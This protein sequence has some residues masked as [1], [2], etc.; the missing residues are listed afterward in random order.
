MLSRNHCVEGFERCVISPAFAHVIHRHGEVDAIGLAIDV[1]VD[2]VE[3]DF[4]LLRAERQSAE[5]AETTG[6]CNG[7]DYVS[8]MRE[9]KDRKFDSKTLGNRSA[10]GF[11]FGSVIGLT[12]HMRHKIYNSEDNVARGSGPHCAD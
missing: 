9:S 3:L 4:K 7:S 1:F 6:V 2:P 11:P 10:H 5:N 12:G 8:T